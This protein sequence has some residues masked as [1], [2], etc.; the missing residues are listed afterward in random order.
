[1]C[2]ISMSRG[3]RAQ[4]LYCAVCAQPRTRGRFLKGSRR[5]KAIAPY[6]CEHRLNSALRADLHSDPVRILDVEAGKVAFQWHCTA[7]FE[8]AHREIL[9][10]SGYA[11]REVVHN[12]G[13]AFAVQRHQRP[14]VAETHDAARAL[15]AHHREAEDLLIEIDRTLQV[16]NL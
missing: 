13:R 3:S 8:I 2:A 15:L 10:E 16:G 14:A 7:L 5:N 6:G 4:L 12:S 9:V 1:T 11:D